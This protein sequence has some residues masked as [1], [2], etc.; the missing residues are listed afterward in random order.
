MFGEQ[1]TIIKTENLA[2]GPG[3]LQQQMGNVKVTVGKYPVE[4]FSPPLVT[5]N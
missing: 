1:S 4:R 2:S 5:Y 3:Q